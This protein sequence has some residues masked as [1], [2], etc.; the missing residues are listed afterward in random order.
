MFVHQS[1]KFTHQTNFK[2]LSFQKL[3]MQFTTLS[4]LAVFALTHFGVTVQAFSGYAN[5]CTSGGVNKYSYGYYLTAKCGDGKGGQKTTNLLLGNC[6][7][8]RDGQLVAEKE[9]V[10]STLTS[11][12]CEIKH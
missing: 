5:S 12:C 4:A 8:N 9:S 2:H 3:K 6:Y 10:P 1:E 7:G 11:R